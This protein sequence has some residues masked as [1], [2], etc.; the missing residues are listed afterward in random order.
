MPHLHSPFLDPWSDHTAPPTPLPFFLLYLRP[1]SA[2][3]LTFYPMA[4]YFS[5][6]TVVSPL[7]PVATLFPGLFHT[8]Y[9]RSPSSSGRNL[10]DCCTV[11]AG[12]TS[13]AEAP[14]T[15]RTPQFS[16][17]LKAESESYCPCGAPPRIDSSTHPIQ[18]CPANS[19]HS[20][21]RTS[22]E[23]LSCA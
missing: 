15:L 22:G 23:W 21:G 18:M 13:R 5:A 20:P 11:Q 9:P 6:P 10:D 7:V 12:G 8:P 4:S 14:P 19:R 2:P 16:R 3:T 17:P 1:S